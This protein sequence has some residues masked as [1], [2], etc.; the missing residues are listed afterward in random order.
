LALEWV[1]DNIAKFGGD[2]SQVTVMGESAGGGSTIHQITAYGGSKGKVPFQQAIVE[3]GAFLPVTSKQ[4]QEDIFQRVLTTA[5]VS[6][7]QDARNLS[8]EVLQ[9]TNAKIVGQAAWGDFI[10]SELQ[11]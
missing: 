9:L 6:T 11:T 8:T 10:F 4:K 1:Q 2:P 7:L 5:G 3:S